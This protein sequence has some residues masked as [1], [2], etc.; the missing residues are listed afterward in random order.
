MCRCFMDIVPTNAPLLLYNGSAW[1]DPVKKEMLRTYPI[2]LDSQVFLEDLQ[3]RYPKLTVEVQGIENHYI[4][5]KNTI[6]EEYCTNNGAS[7]A[8]GDTA[9]VERPFIKAFDTRV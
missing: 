1:Y 7:W 5:R 3:S 9:A 4:F 2:D 8:Y 6:W